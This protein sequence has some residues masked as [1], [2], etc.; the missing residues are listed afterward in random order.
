MSNNLQEW[1]GQIVPRSF[2]VGYAVLSYVVSYVGAWTTLE[3]INRRT[4]GRGLYNWYILIGSSVSMGGIAIWCMH[5]VGNRAV[6]LGNGQFEIH[7]VYSPGFT[8]LSFFVPTTV[9]LVAFIALG[10]NDRISIVRVVVGGTLAGLAIC[11]MHYLGQAGISNYSCVYSIG[12]VVGS[13]IVAV[14]ATIAALTV[15]FVLRAAWTNSW[16]KRALC[17]IVLAGAVFG[18]HWTAAVGTQYRLKQGATSSPAS[19]I[20]RDLTVIVIVLSIVACFILFVF[21][22]L[23]QRRRSR[24]ANRAQHVVLASA[25]FDAN[26]R[27]LVTPEGTLPN[28]KVT[29]SYVERSLDE[30]FGVTHPVF[31]WIFRTTR[32]WSSISG[33]LPGMRSHLRDTAVYGGSRPGTKTRPSLSNDEGENA[34]DYAVIFRELFC[35]AA[36]DLAG[37]LNEPL[38]N[39][40]V[41]FDEVLGTGQKPSSKLN[42]R[43]NS[44]ESTDLESD[45][46]SVSTLSRG[47]LLFLVRR[48]NRREADQLAASG[49]RFAEIQNVAHIIARNMQIKCNDLHGRLFSMYEYASETHILNPGVHLACF[50]IRASVQGGFDVLVRRD[51]RNQLPTMQLPIDNL[52]SWQITFLSQ[53]DGASVTACLKFLKDNSA[54]SDNATREQNFAAQLYKAVVELKEEINDPFFA[55][56]LLIGTPVSAPCYTSDGG[57]KPAQAMLITFRVIVPVQFR[58]QSVKLG[59]TPL[60]F[61][62]TQQYVY[63]NSPDHAS[64][65]RKIHKEFGPILNK[66]N[67]NTNGDGKSLKSPTSLGKFPRRLKKNTSGPSDVSMPTAAPRAHT[68]SSSRRFWKRQSGGESRNLPKASLDNTSEIQLVETQAFGGI[69]V[70]QEVSVDVKDVE[71][72]SPDRGERDGK[73]AEP[74]VIHL[75]TTGEATRDL[76][77]SETYVDRLLSVCIAARR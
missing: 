23:A 42:D 64:F 54:S 55:D 45:G 39:V 28:Q 53:L 26:G 56:A 37:Q 38:E 4:S 9:L 10:S 7:I 19:S 72:R 68:R 49:Y 44:R 75:G 65:A 43:S 8:A 59:F 47:Q 27:I 60:G 35:I 5:Y 50:A 20:S 77:D 13:I 22:I 12:H 21:A 73:D 31:H 40:G 41:L 2:S 34:D 18:M 25:I 46:A 30:E 66:K 24:S 76:D 17:A 70:S 11:G 69:M 61:F 71:E 48:V 74:Q 14:A 16:W 1:E 32:N 52:S 51:A 29:T 57:A 33:L 15:F 62:R 6:E 63:G 58:A 67:L 3:L 36:A